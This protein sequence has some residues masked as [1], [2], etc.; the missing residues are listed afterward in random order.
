[1][2]DR[3]ALHGLSSYL[4]NVGNITPVVQPVQ[5]WHDFFTPVGHDQ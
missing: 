2:S 3:R 5:F 1:M 4:S